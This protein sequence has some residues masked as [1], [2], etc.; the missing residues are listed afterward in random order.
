MNLYHWFNDKYF[1][2]AVNLDSFYDSCLILP[3]FLTENGYVMQLC[4][5]GVFRDMKFYRYEIYSFYST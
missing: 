4:V 3:L 1:Y 2:I 5:K